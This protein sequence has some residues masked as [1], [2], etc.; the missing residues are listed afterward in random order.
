MPAL[1]P[2]S[3]ENERK[4]SRTRRRLLDAAAKLFKQ[5]GYAGTR[6]EDIADAAAIR[7]ASVYYHFSSKEEL[8]GEVLDQGIARCFDAVTAAVDALGPEASFRAR[9][10]AAIA[11]HLDM[12][13]R[14]GDYT[15]ANI[16][17]FGQV[18]EPIRRR[19][20]PLREAYGDYWRGLL[21]SGQ[22]SGEL[23]K[24]AD[25]SLLRM[26]LL[27]S[28]NWAIEWYDPRRKT[29]D[30]IAVTVVSMFLDGVAGE[31][32]T[33]TGDDAGKVVSLDGARRR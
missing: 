8:M 16:R 1:P 20:W 29:A 15:A 12:L 30:E 4:S 3:A 27:G 28:L 2:V 10:H 23:K 17:S 31:A 13:L 11:A 22:R 6:Q 24:E 26:L 7:A 25:L 9:L 32:G 21:E 14:H 18:P 5:R 33:T 19:H